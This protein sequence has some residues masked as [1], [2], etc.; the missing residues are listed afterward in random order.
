M[1]IGPVGGPSL[2]RVGPGQV[3]PDQVGPVIL[4]MVIPLE[5]QNYKMLGKG[6]TR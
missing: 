3:G 1:I 4:G 5:R 2:G 6:K